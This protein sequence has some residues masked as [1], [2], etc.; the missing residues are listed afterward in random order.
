MKGGFM[1]ICEKLNFIKQA[2]IIFN[3]ELS[4]MRYSS[5][6]WKTII[7]SLTVEEI[8]SDEF[9]EFLVDT[10]NTEELKAVEIKIPSE[11]TDYEIKKAAIFNI[12]CLEYS[13]W[14]D[15]K[16]FNE[17]EYYDGNFKALSQESTP[18]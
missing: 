13:Y 4:S 10:I 7:K 2:N 9:N 18:I 11:D 16:L 6:S 5:N 8:I 1:N 17:N 12:F 15:G 14:M 3:Y